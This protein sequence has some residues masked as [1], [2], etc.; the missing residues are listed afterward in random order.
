MEFSTDLHSFNLPINVTAVDYVCVLTRTRSYQH[1]SV[2]IWLLI[3]LNKTAFLPYFFQTNSILIVLITEKQNKILAGR[4][5]FFFSENVDDIWQY[6]EFCVLP[7]RGPLQCHCVWI[8]VN[9]KH[10]SLTCKHENTCYESRTSAHVLPNTETGR[11]T[12]ALRL[13]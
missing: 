13:Q 10:F 4:F 2:L 8:Q 11:R 3:C 7:E 12:L 1:K 5:F 9:T 6:F